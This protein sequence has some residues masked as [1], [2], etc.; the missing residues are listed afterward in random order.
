MGKPKNANHRGTRGPLIIPG[1]RKAVISPPV[2]DV[3][4]LQ[5]QGRPITVF[6]DAHVMLPGVIA[7]AAVPAQLT[8]ITVLTNVLAHETA[9]LG[10]R[11]GAL[12]DVGIP[13]LRA[14]LVALDAEVK[15][16]R[17]ELDAIG[18]GVAA[19]SGDGPAKV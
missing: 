18:C 16:L 2:L 15:E 5:M 1:D 12:E 10:D 4:E 9:D 7:D 8:A 19:Q 3:V 17:D 11:V 14:S 13:E 6:R